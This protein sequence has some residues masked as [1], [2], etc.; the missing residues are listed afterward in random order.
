MLPVGDRTTS[1]KQRRETGPPKGPRLR[2]RCV[3]LEVQAQNGG[4]AG[5]RCRRLLE[6]EGQGALVAGRTSDGGRE[7]TEEVGRQGNTGGRS[8]AVDGQGGAGDTCA[9]TAQR[10]RD[11]RRQTGADHTR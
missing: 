6:A 10:A 9:R 7:A 3:D 8:N 2:V 1:P 5:E 11:T 4:E